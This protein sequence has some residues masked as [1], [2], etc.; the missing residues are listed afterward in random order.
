[1][2]KIVE[3][4]CSFYDGHR[5]KLIIMRNAAIILLISAF[6]VLATGSYSQTTQLSLKLKDAT[7]KEVLTEIENQ[8][9]FYFL[10]NSELIDV[11]RRVDISVK[12]EKIGDILSRLF[13]NDEV[14]V[15]ISD[16]HIV[17]TPA[18]EKSAQQQQKSVSGRVTDARN[19]PL[20]G[21]TVVVKGTIQGTVTNADGIYTLPNVPGDATLVFSF[22]GM[23]GQ[24]VTVAGNTSI[25]AQLEEE[26]IGIDEVIAIGYGTQSKKKITSAISRVDMNG[27]RDMPVTSSGHILQ[28]RASGVSVNDNTG[29]PGE[30]PR[31]TI[32][33]LS[34][35]NAG[36]GPLIVIDGFPVGNS[37]PR[38]LNP[39][40]IEQMTVLKDA[41]SASIYGARGSNG[42]IL[43]Q[44]I[45]AD[46]SKTEI[47]YSVSEGFQ[48]F[49]DNW[50]VP[51]LNAIQYAQY[52]KER[53]EE[54][55]A[56]SNQN[57]P[58]PQIYLDVL[59]NPDAYRNLPTWQDHV[60]RQGTN[61][62]LHNHNL[63]IKAGNE[64]LRAVISGGYQKQDGILP[65]TDFQRFSFRT[66]IQSDITSWLK[67]T[68]SISVAHTEDNS[69]PETGQ[70]GI[71]MKAVTTSPIQTPYDQNGKIRPY[72]PA[73]SPGYFSHPNPL[74]EASE[75]INNTVGKDL[76]ATFG[77]DIQIV[78]GLHY[79]PQFYTR[80]FTQENNTFTP[81]TIG[82]YEIGSASNLSPGAPP[83]V[84]SASNRY[85]NLTNWGL[86]NL[87][88]YSKTIGNHSLGILFGYTAQK[89]SGEV[90]QINGSG[91]PADNKID[92]LEATE[93]SA[94]V[95][96]Y[97][98]W[99]LNASFFRLN[100]DYKAKYLVEVNF[101]REGSSKFGAN[102]KYGNFP[103]ASVGW[104]ISEEK[105]YP[106]D[107]FINELKLR[108]SYGITGN[109]SIGDFDR[110]GRL[111]SIPNLN[112]VSN[113]YNYVLNNNI[114]VGKTLTS[115]GN[116]DLKW[117]TSRQLDIGFNAD[118]FNNRLSV[119]AGYFKKSTFDMLFNVSIPDAS[120]FSSTRD[121]VGEMLNRGWDIEI[122]ANIGSK[123]FLW[124]SNLSISIMENKV[125]YMPEEIS[126]IIS[127]KNV[128]QVGY[129]VGSLYGYV[130]DG[131]F[132]TQE[133][134]NDPNLF[135]YPGARRL[136]AYIYKDVNG[137]KK[138]D[139]TDMDVLGNPHPKVQ[140]GFNN[141]FNYKNFSLSILTT[142][143]FGYDIL[144]NANEVLYNGK[145]RWN[146]S[147]KFLERWVSP[148]SPGAG[149]IPQ[150]PHPGTHFASNLW[151]ESGN[152]IWIKNITLGYQVP[153]AILNKTKV[154]SALRFYCSVQ[155]AFK[156][157]NYSGPNPQV[158][159]HGGGSSPQQFG[160]DDFSYP[161]NRTISIGTNIKF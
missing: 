59:N 20:P 84:N 142:G 93:T 7:I 5:K 38:S 102:N 146:V 91:F 110:F 40:D 128:T 100:Y 25:N 34:S 49:P 101:R 55:N 51:V 57:N 155:N 125:I 130:I 26:T 72:I 151:V 129:P 97:S 132:N 11:T 160:I 75:I 108:A 58:V 113:N 115:L 141:S 79:K 50:R 32:H 8:S 62:M 71:F 131:I 94:S 89:E 148:S 116:Q 9:E 139:G 56:Y 44:T 22:V 161:V 54:L 157:T 140:L 65:G 152:H 15:S 18:T 83:F 138:I 45:N 127:G 67:S 61:A 150:I 37:I 134:L 143:S 81:T 78:E 103:S 46:K 12:V 70:R 36:I 14:N 31:I 156:I 16:R 69:I 77:L 63:T 74:F 104:R 137:D 119:S 64:K 27:V 118:L 82:R 43:I 29:R 124:S 120:G 66:N 53:V 21:V 144:P 123:E 23:K 60:F 158:S 159:S 42:V 145:G 30:T 41:A 135:A 6:Q 114:V 2:K 17:L 111:V 1:M 92:Y 105:F 112:N 3:R 10:Y 99:A 33:G 107:F 133:Q 13:S 86:D 98:N 52:N 76:N 90:A 47:E 154:I 35:I 122:G 106:E 96:D 85:W 117:E 73:D 153:P 48:Y 149:L 28:G 136:G 109:S 19:Q 87:L 88:T 121:N 80:L 39:S 24:E 95:A 4:V 126:K 147:T 68:A